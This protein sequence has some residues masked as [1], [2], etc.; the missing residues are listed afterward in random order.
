[1]PNDDKGYEQ[2]LATVEPFGLYLSGCSASLD[3]DLFW[4]LRER[5]THKGIRQLMARHRVTKSGKEFFDIESEFKIVI[6]D[7]DNS[8]AEALKIECAFQ[9]HLHNEKT[10][11]RAYAERF[12]SSEFRVVI[13]PYFRQF[14]S[15][16][17]AWMGIPPI[18]IPISIGEPKDVAADRALKA[19]STELAR[20]SSR[21]RGASG[22]KASSP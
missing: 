20:P 4:K 22:R 17:T 6:T 13:W 2:F 7:P 8:E 10:T 15:D 9:A 19:S 5:K 11:T 3:R 18:F 14:V 1:M 12:A 16:T 21:S